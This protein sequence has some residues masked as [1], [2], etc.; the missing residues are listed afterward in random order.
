MFKAAQGACMKNKWIAMDKATGM[1]KSKLAAGEVPKDEVRA[2]LE[3]AKA[4]GGRAD[5]FDKKAWDGL[6]RRKMVAPVKE[7]TY[8]LAKGPKFALE[9]KKMAADLT[10]DMLDSDSWS[11]TDFKPV[12][13][14]SLGKPTGGGRLHPLLK[15]RAEFRKV[16]MQMGFEEMPT[17]RF[18]ESSFWNFDVLFQPQAHPARDAHDT[19]FL[20]KPAKTLSLP[21][22][23]L[24][25]VADTHETGGDT[26]SWGYRYKWKREEATKN[27]LRTHTTAISS[28]MLYKL[29]QDVAAG[30]PFTPKKYFSIDRVFRNET[31]DA[32]H[33]AEFHQVEGLVA[34]RN[35]GLQDLIGVIHTFFS[36]IGF[37]ELRFKPAFNPYTEPSMEI[38]GFHPDLNVWT[39]IGNSG[40][41]R[42]EMLQPMGLPEDV[43]V[44]AWG[45]SLERPTMIKYRISNIRDLFG[46]KIDLQKT[47]RAPVCRFAAAAAS[48]ASA[49]IAPAPEGKDDDD[50]DE[51]K[52]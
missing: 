42:P 51:K 37:R 30:G 46:F 15:V 4:E 9:R 44:I 33:L 35:L 20:T 2:M 28:Q 29:G 40:I 52:Q 6:K 5:L 11:T 36:K 27:L 10:K 41:F 8:K 32:T 48:D 13:F 21:E 34:D 47:E 39:E 26:G 25:K 45:L 7:N 14:K 1:V 49:P 38:F 23:Y 22:D 24:A 16:L 12:N 3:Q 31:M 50:D 43:R 17:A 18:V 19:F